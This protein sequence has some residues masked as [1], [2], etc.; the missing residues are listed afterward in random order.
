M[1]F[2]S[3]SAK[4]YIAVILCLLAEGGLWGVFAYIM[5][6]YDPPWYIIFWSLVAILGCTVL[7]A[8]ALWK[9]FHG[10]E[11]KK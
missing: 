3:L 10:R 6:K 4:D 7:M 11:T 9:R 1:D 8:V 2:K 5:G